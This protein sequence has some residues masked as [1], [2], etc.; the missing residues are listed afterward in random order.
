MLGCI[1]PMSSPMMNKMLGFCCGACFGCCCALAGRLAAT[2]AVAPASRP[3]DMCRLI[4]ILSSFLLR[5]EF[6]C[7]AD[8]SARSI[9]RREL[10]RPPSSRNAAKT[11]MTGGCVDRLGMTSG[12]AIATTV[13]G[14]TE[15]R[16]ALDHL[17]R[18]LDVRFARVVAVLLAPAAR[19]LRNAAGF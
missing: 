18:N 1:K 2:I 5:L 4:F 19:V 6:Q 9:G 3:S 16:P 7:G 10:R 11:E 13:V 17:A 12:R 8:Q 14:G 15:V